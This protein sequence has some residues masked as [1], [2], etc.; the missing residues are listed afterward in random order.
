[1]K[2][3]FGFLTGSCL[4]A[5]M[6]AAS[7]VAQDLNRSILPIPE[8]VF[9]GEIG[10]T[11]ADSEKDFPRQIEPPKGAPNV[12]II[13]TDDVGFAASQTFGGPIPTPAFDR[14][15][16]A[17]LRYNRFHTTAQCSP[18]R[19]A[20]LTG[21]N[22]HTCGTGSIMEMGVGYPGYNTLVSKKLAGIGEI[23]KYNGYNTAWF[24]KNH[25]VPDWQNSQ[26]GP[27]DLWPSGLG[28]EYFYGFLGGDT[29]QWA[30]ALFENTTAIEP[31]H[32]DPDYHFD[33]DLADKAIERLQLLHAI[34]PEKPFFFYYVPGTSHA[35]H[36]APKEW[37]EKFDGWFDD[38][39]D[40]TRAKTFARQKK[41]GVIPANTKLTK[42]PDAIPAW[43]SLDAEHKKV[44]A[45]MMEVYAGALAH[46]DYQIN[47]ILDALEETGRMDNT[48]VI[49]IMGDNGASGEGGD[50]G[51]LN[52]MTLFNGVI[53]DFDDVKKTYDTLGGPMHFNHKP[54]GWA[55]AMSTPFQ[56]TKLVASHFGGT[57]NAMAISWPAKIKDRGGLRDQFHHVI[58]ILPT[59][60]ECADIPAPV[61]VNGFDQKPIEGVSM[62]Y[63]FDQADAPGRRITQYFEIYARRGVYHD[64]WVAATTP[65]S[66]PWI[67]SQSSKNAHTEYK[68]ELYNVDQDFSEADDLAAQN[69]EKLQALKDR[70][71]VEATKYNVLP[72]DDSN[73]E[74]FDVANR[75]SLTAGRT[76]FTYH[77]GM[78]RIPEGSAPDLKNRSWNVE[79]KVKIPEEGA[80]GLLFTQ[81][82]RF[83]GIGL[84]VLEGKPVFLYNYLGLQR[85]RVAGTENLSPGEHTIT[86]QFKYTGGGAGKPADVV[87][88]VDGK[89]V[90]QGRVEVTIPIRLSLDETL[91]IGED[92]GTPVSEDY[93]PPFKFTGEIEKVSVQLK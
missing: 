44:F 80:Q 4:L 7:A 57:R 54:A 38:G 93:H 61:K 79:A 73:I 30:P 39:W 31:P 35:P 29:N 34:A 88:L 41:L 45:R 11:P 55:H 70:F 52:E 89:Q 21:R 20:L 8:P 90:A 1:M 69:P 13:M 33:V 18:T 72:L 58:D 25:N 51:M 3:A 49:Y 14:I 6:A 83:N 40:A 27:Y 91:D 37:I 9:A 36:H 5:A 17:G 85:T 53:E 16:R 75:P 28:F 50:Q 23:L 64:G 74:R 59:V 56:W 92:T 60:L 76:T 19:A 2:R 71:L 48:L 86:A 46:C 82:G 66:A 22:H 47:R 65:K 84:Y 12:L 24:G 32:D 43:D 63:T 42:R 87:L 68:W 67:P 62:A 26:V 78:T 81:G 10:I 15:A 77:E